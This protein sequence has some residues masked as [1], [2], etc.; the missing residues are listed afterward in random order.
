MTPPGPPRGTPNFS[1]PPY[2]T[3]LS[4]WTSQP[5]WRAS[6][7]LPAIWV[8]LS[9]SSDPS[10]EPP[11]L[12]WPSGRDSQPISALTTSPCSPEGLPLIPAHL[13]DS[14]LL[15]SPHSHTGGPP[16]PSQP[17]GRAFQSRPTLPAIQKGLPTFAI[18]QGGPPDPSRHSGRDS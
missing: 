6:P 11:N 4:R 12:S 18:P 2:P 3:R 8:G 15:P 7:T 10:G 14:R 13:G 17:S 1:S 5:S 16:D 9:A